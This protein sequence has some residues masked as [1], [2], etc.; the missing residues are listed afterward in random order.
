M[1]TVDEKEEE[2]VRICLNLDAH[3]CHSLSRTLRCA[4]LA[5][6]SYS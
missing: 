3:V 6:L 4:I 5:Q 1:F 2:K